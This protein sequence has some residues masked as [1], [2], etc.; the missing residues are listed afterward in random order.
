MVLLQLHTAMRPDEVTII[1]LC[2]ID[3]SDEVWTYIPHT[4]KTEHYDH[5]RAVYLGPA[6][7]AILR[8]WLDRPDDVYLFSPR[9][10]VAAARAKRRKV[11]STAPEKFKY[12]RAP[13][14]HY[15]DESYCRAIKK[16]CQRAGVPNWTPNQLRHTA[17]TYIRETYG[18]EAAKII[19]GHQS[20]VTTEIYAEKDAKIAKNIMKKIG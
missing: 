3:Q 9:E 14:E 15:D 1:R 12:D 20:A 19:L 7:Q 17:A 5:T 2:D 18:L 6:C 10:V 4:H 13:R 8:P 11:P 16:A